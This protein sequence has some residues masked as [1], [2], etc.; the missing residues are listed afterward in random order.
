MTKECTRCMEDK[1]IGDFHI[2]SRICKV[3]RSLIG[4]EYR[5]ANP[6]ETQLVKPLEGEVFEYIKGREVFYR[7]SS[8]GRL[9]SLCKSVRGKAR[10]RRKE[11]VLKPHR[12][13]YTGYY[14]YVFSSWGNGEKDKRENIHRL[15]ALHFI[16]NPDCL[17]EVNHK[18]GDKLNNRVDNLEWV[19][20]EQNI[21][22]GFINGLIKTPKGEAAHNSKLTEKIVLEIFNSKIGPRKLSRDTGIPYSCIAGIR[23]GNTWNHITGLPKKYYGKDKHKTRYT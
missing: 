20:R 13:S 6:I 1:D 7:I 3:C 18:D 15:V 16:P 21:Q 9:T 22:H 11:K 12:N 17:P 4:K 10:N 19:T 5:A 23:N 14:A 2:K 8:F